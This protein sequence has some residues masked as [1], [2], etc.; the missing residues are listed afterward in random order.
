VRGKLF[1][2][3]IIIAMVPLM[4]GATDAFGETYVSATAIIEQYHRGIGTLNADQKHLAETALDARPDSIGFFESTRFPIRSHYPSADYME[5]AETIL[6]IAE[7]SWEEQVLGMGF[8]APPP[9]CGNGGSDHLDIYLQDLPQGVG[10]YAAFSCYI[11]ETPEADAASFVA[12]ALTVPDEFIRGAVTHEFNHVLQNGIDYWENI[13]FKENTATWVMDRVFDDENYYFSYLR[14]YQ[15]NPDWPI[16]KFSTSNTYQYG[17]CMLLHFLAEYYGGGAPAIIVD[18]WNAC[19]QDQMY[20][21]PDYLEAMDRVIPAVSGGRDSLKDALAEYS[22]W[23]TITG[24]RDDGAHFHDGGLWPD[25]AEVAMDT[26]IDLAQGLPAPV[27]PQNPP[28]DYGFSYI[29]L[30]NPGALPGA[31][32]VEFQGDPA[33]DWSV[34]LIQC[35]DGYATH[36][37]R[38]LDLNSSRGILLLNPGMLTRSDELILAV[39]NLS[40]PSFDPDQGIDGTRRSYTMKFMAAQPDTS[41]QIWTDQPMTC[42]GKMFGFNTEMEHYDTVA[43]MDFWLFLEI[44]GAFFSI[45]TD[46]SGVPAPRQVNLIPGAVTTD[47]VFSF[48]MPGL[49]VSLALIWHAALLQGTAVIDYQVMFSNLVTSCR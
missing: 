5:K 37:V 40:E 24:A 9:D 13:T 14:S 20:N 2:I 27:T 8:K 49:D 7:T 16:H 30:V 21:E 39:V 19:V 26:V 31:A 29:K 23:R 4:V 18:I 42:P 34:R 44:A 11:D 48:E 45:Y 35:R 15:R 33:V 47:Q 46:G 28:Y 41:L 32:A 3:S 12:L 22:V 36:I 17:E 10:G 43:T 25:G 1:F 6:A 38:S